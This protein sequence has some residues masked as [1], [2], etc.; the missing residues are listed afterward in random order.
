MLRSLYSYYCTILGGH[1]T[2]IA[3]IVSV[4]YHSGPFLISFF[5]VGGAGADHFLQ[6]FA[7]E[8]LFFEQ[9]LG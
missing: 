3:G 6:I 1:V 4:I 8:H 9:C 5:G 2:I 7:A